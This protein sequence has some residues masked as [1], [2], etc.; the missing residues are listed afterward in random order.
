MNQQ[1]YASNF[2]GTK[3]RLAASEAARLG[4]QFTTLNKGAMNMDPKDIIT[5]LGRLSDQMDVG[6]ANIFAAAGQELPADLADKAD[7]IYTDPTSSLYA[8]KGPVKVAKPPEGSATAPISDSSSAPALKP[9]TDDDKA[10][11]KTLMARDGRDAVIAH[12]KASGYDT[13]GL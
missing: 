3:Q 1:L 12:L 13:S 2:R 8:Y 5:E 9:L 7:K 4:D 6:H 10:Q 11:A